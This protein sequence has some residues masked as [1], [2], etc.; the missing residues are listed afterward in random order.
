M[1]IKDIMQNVLLAV[2][3]CFLFGCVSQVIKPYIKEVTTN[4]DGSITTRETSADKVTGATLGDLNKLT[5]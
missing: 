3:I 1:T 5:K 4:K 2:V